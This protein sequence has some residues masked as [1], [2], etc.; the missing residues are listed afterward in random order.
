MA[1]RKYFSDI[2]VNFPMSQIAKAYLQR[3][4]TR[5]RAQGR[6]TTS[7]RNERVQIAKK[8]QWKGKIFQWNTKYFVEAEIVKR[9]DRKNVVT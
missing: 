4:I 8:I 3:F 1:H 5:A 2:F 7:S 6:T 9:A